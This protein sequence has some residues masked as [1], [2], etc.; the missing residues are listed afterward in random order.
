M[1]AT[2]VFE[3]LQVT[4]VVRFWVVPS[5]KVPVAVNCWVRPSAMDGGSVGVTARDIN[6]AGVIVRAV[7]PLIPVVGSVPVMVVA[8]TETLVARP[9]LSTA[10]LMVA[11]LGFDELQV[12]LVVRS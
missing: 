10:L 8:P 11:I 7:E 4:D 6:T 3:E 12:R 9:L 1:V 5:V 2:E